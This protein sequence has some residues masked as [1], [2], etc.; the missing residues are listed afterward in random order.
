VQGRAHR[1]APSVEGRLAA[2][3]ARVGAQSAPRGAR[4]MAGGGARA[5]EVEGDGDE[6]GTQMEKRAYGELTDMVDVRT[7]PKPSIES[8]MGR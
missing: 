8:D 5:E 3:A 1:R 7:P 4:G 6:G 2:R